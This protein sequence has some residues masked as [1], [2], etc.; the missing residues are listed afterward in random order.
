MNLSQLIFAE[1]ALVKKN[2]FSKT[3]LQ[4]LQV[5]FSALQFL[6]NFQVIFG[7]KGSFILQLFYVFIK[8]VFVS[9]SKLTFTCSKSAIKTPEKL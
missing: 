5:A 3:T 6:I 2:V 1:F 7:E 9:V 4:T 8:T